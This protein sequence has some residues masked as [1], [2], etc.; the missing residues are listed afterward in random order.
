MSFAAS[1]YLPRMESA[2]I[3]NGAS[4]EFI[5]QQGFLIILFPDLPGV[6]LR[7]MIHV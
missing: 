3:E 4:P 6:K 1:R 7:V 5:V 2:W